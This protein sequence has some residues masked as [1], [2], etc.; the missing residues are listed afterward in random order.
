[1]TNYFTSPHTVRKA[2]RHSALPL[3]GHPDDLV[4]D[5]R[6]TTEEKRVLLAS[7]ASDANALPYVP[8]LRQL[9]DGSIIKVDEIDPACPEALDATTRFL[10]AAV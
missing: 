4:S 2:D 1:M 5:T 9:P 3:F 8:S 10:A 6:L 7:W